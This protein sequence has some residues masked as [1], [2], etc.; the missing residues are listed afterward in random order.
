MGCGADIPAK[1]PGYFCDGCRAI[2]G[3]ESQERCNSGAGEFAEAVERVE[4]SLKPLL[5]GVI[6]WQESGQGSACWPWPFGDG[7]YR[8]QAAS[9]WG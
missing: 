4:L 9:C 8:H 5:L 2:D 1:A 6:V 7:T 3:K